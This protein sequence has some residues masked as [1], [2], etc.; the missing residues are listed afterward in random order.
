MDLKAW[1]TEHDT[2]YK[3][4]AAAVGVDPSRISRAVAGLIMPSPE[5]V[6][7]IK[8]ETGGRVTSNDLHDAYIRY[9]GDGR[10]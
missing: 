9:D 10:S 8:R 3:E 5:T 1:L 4:F 2:S 6:E 7:A